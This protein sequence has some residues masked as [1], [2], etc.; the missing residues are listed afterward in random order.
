MILRLMVILTCLLLK[1]FTHPATISSL[2][3]AMKGT[4]S[5]KSASG[6]NKSKKSTLEVILNSPFTRIMKVTNLLNLEIRLSNAN[7]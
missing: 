3:M 7:Q 4:V 6:I 1:F 5:Q 2:K